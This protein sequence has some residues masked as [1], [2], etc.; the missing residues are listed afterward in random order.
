MLTAHERRAQIVSM[1]TAEGHS[2]V[3]GL[4]AH[5][6]VTPETIR[7]D[8]AHLEEKG[9]IERIHGGAVSPNSPARNTWIGWE[10][11]VDHDSLKSQIAAK[12]FTLIKDG[13]CSIFIDAGHSTSALASIMAERY[14]GQQWQ[15]V[16]N[17]LNA[18][19]IL[20]AGG[21]PGVRL[22]GGAMRAYTRAV[23]G[24]EAVANLGSLR[25]D[26]AFMGTNGISVEHGVSTPDSSEA[27]IKRA[28]VQAA[29]RSII[30]C[31]SEKFGHDYMNTFAPLTAI[32]TVVT[33]DEAGADFRSAME[34][35]SVAVL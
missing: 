11:H 24:D 10:P 6:R 34:R 23:V 32:H 22:L 20:S 25:A 18:A 2:S 12:A 26:I 30:L 19:M 14:N 27:A 31:E 16:T 4:A 35:C 8:L 9:S 1:T 13:P 3:T 21:V 33:E 7:R 29:H 17:S 28:M 5:F 15:V